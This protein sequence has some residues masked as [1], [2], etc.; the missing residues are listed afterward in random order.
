MDQDEC[1][2]QQDSSPLLQLP[3]DVLLVIFEQLGLADILSEAGKNQ[4]HIVDL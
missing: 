4:S 3:T 2:G 1:T